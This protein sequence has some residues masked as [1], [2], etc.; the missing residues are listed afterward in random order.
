MIHKVLLSDDGDKCVRVINE[1]QVDA[2]LKQSEVI[3]DDF[4]QSEKRS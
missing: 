1:R 3:S 2:S 4:R